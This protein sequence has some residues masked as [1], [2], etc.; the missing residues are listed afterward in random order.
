MADKRIRKIAAWVLRIHV[1]VGTHCYWV[2]HLGDRAWLRRWR[3]ARTNTRLEFQRFS[4]R[5]ATDSFGLTTA[6]WREVKGEN[7]KVKVNYRFKTWQHSPLDSAWT[8]SWSPAWCWWPPRA[9]GTF[10]PRS[11]RW[12]DPGWSWRRSRSAGRVATRWDCS[13]SRDTSLQITWH[14]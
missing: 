9:R 14:I 3:V 13:K 6:K 7:H 10:R 11:S 8:R 4:L 5:S 1:D 2:G 12:R